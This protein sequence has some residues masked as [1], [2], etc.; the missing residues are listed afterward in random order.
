M[1]LPVPARFGF[2]KWASSCIAVAATCVALLGQLASGADTNDVQPNDNSHSAGQLTHGVLKLR[3]EI[4][5]GVWNPEGENG[6][7]IAVQAFAEEGHPLMN[8]G[9][10]IRVRRG[11][12]VHISVHSFLP[13]QTVII[14]GLSSHAGVSGTLTIKPLGTEEAE[15]RAVR[16]GVYF[17][18]GTTTGA[19]LDK[20]T[21]IDSQLSGAL[22]VDPRRASTIPDRIFVLGH[23]LREGDAKSIP[24]KPDLE[25]WVINGKSWPN[26]ERLI[27][28]VGQL[29]RWNWINATDENHPLHLHGHYFLVEAMGD[30]TRWVQLPVSH[31]R[32]AATEVLP[33]GSSFTLSWLPERSGK[34][35]FHCHVLF[36]ISPQLRQTPDISGAHHEEHDPSRHMAGLVL[37]IT[38][39]Q[40]KMPIAVSALQPRRLRLAV[41][42]RQGVQLHGLPGLGYELVD[43]G[44]QRIG[45]RGV[46]TSPGPPII[47][48]R[49]QPVEIAVENRSPQSTSVHWHGI[50][51]E[52]YYD[53]VPGWGGE[54]RQVTPPIRPGETFVARFT[55]PRAGTFMYHT[56]L[57]DYVQL[58]T[59]LYGALIVVEPGQQYDPESDKIFVLS[60]GGPDDEKDPFLIN[61][62]AAPAAIELCAGKRYR[63]RF[64]MI[65]P[66]PFLSVTLD[67]KGRHQLWTSI[68]KD[69]ATLPASQSIRLAA[70]FDIYPGETYDFEFRPALAGALRLTASQPF[71]KLQTSLPI[72]VRSR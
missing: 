7:Q 48:T 40:P 50:E 37:G 14:H 49:G 31:R 8:P 24:P 26:T 18:W 52:S 60:R 21:G 33:S 68:A 47:L 17:Y 53:G 43:A 45:D 5:G 69:G 11:T 25:T 23:W 61:G 42:Q 64:I 56:H 28:P 66:A 32:R 39:I 29:V 57:N 12:R 59:G 67:R 46:F 9:P 15:F 70:S 4:R 27:Y 44:D 58:S 72:V 22:I 6:P 1:P 3:L 36:H 51:L 38:V 71:F 30:Q 35:L 19:S 10:L 13:S 2:I 63:F 20:R 41:G 62:S 34:W 16:P 65:T 54:G 55:P